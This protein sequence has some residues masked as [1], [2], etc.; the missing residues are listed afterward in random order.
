MSMPLEAPAVILLGLAG[1]IVGIRGMKVGRLKVEKSESLK[2]A[3]SKGQTTE[4]RPQT[5]DRASNYSLLATHYLALCATLYFIG[6]AYFSPVQDLGMEDL[7]LILP[8]GLLYFLAGFGVSGKSGAKLRQGLAWV[9]IA[10][11]LCHLS[12]AVYQLQGEEGFSLSRYFTS[13]KRANGNIVTGMYGY[14]GSF[15]NFT[16]ISGL[17][18]LSFG[19]WGRVPLWVRGL[20]FVL[21][22]IALGLS[23]W[24][25]SR[26]AVLSLVVALAVFGVLLAVSLGGQRTKVRHWGRITLLV[27]GLAGLGIGVAGSIWVFQ[28]RSGNAVTTGAEAAFDSSVR[29]PVWAMAAEQWVDHPVIGAGSRSFSYECFR[30]W[31]PNLST[32]EANPQFAHNEYLQLLADYGL[33]GLLLILA[34]L[35]GHLIIGSK[36][37]HQLSEQV[38]EKGL[39][40]GSN[41]MALAIAGMCGMTAMAVHII[42]DFRTHLLAN[43]LMFVCCAVWV[44]PVGKWVSRGVGKSGSRELGKWVMSLAL[45]VLGLSASYLGFYHLNGGFPLLKNRM[46]KE[47]GTWR[48]ES[49]PRGLWIP[50]LEATVAKAPHY[51]RY[52]RLGTL[53]RLEAAE[54][55][56]EQKKQSIE[57][58]ITAYEASIERHPYNPIPLLNLATIYTATG[59][60]EKADEYFEKSEQLGSARERWFRIHTKWADMH[61]VWA[62]SLWKANDKNGAELHYLRSLKI[63]KEGSVQSGDTTTMYLMVIVEYVQMLDGEKQYEKSDALFE[64]AEKNLPL[65]VI[66][67]RKQNIRR[68]MGEHY[69]RKGKH[70]WYNRQPEE[71]Y[72]AL[73][74]AERSF[75]IHQVV[76]KKQEDLQWKK[77]YDEVKEI[78]KFFKTTGV[79]K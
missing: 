8:A 11:L 65:Y 9:V 15:A 4:G 30:Y 14:R 40:R 49:V 59:E 33:V 23:V 73:V 69:L 58:A 3:E 64:T 53:Y 16:V 75:R 28:E 34:L 27:L 5:T 71:A 12:S 29:M 19:V 1:V 61:R 24:A 77:G 76:L 48:P 67:S 79:G 68:E 20:L 60:F 66:N 10:L 52:Q 2:R 70:L 36:Q 43:L 51:T 35:I 56:G 57:K 39:K 7:M 37:I 47:D 78:L 42:F 74:K 6:R 72:K 44:L 50:V 13:A 63:L 45:I 21:G 62:G 54:Q 55:L 18:C 41:A 32:G 17:L 46:A 38:G 25:L 22:V 26:A 31:S